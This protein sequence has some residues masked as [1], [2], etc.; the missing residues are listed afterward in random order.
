[1]SGR[2]RSVQ[3]YV[4][5]ERM[6][7]PKRMGTLHAQSSGRQEVFSFEY[8]PEWL[9]SEAAFAFDPDL[10]LLEGA[11]YPPQSRSNFGT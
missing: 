3:V 2:Q 8:A 6:G 9:A 5:T 7:G 4:D 1:M 11:Q 10:Q